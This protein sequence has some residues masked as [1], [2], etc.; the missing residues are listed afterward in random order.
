MPFR[1]FDL[2]IRPFMSNGPWQFITFSRGDQQC[3]VSY[4]AITNWKFKDDDPKLKVGAKRTSGRAAFNPIC[5]ERCL[6]PAAYS[7]VTMISL[8]S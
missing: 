1:T 4:Q 6:K 2:I 8:L 7:L 3:P 5:D